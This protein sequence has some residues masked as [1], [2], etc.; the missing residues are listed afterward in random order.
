MASVLL[1]V[2]KT[3]KG[4][5]AVFHFLDNFKPREDVHTIFSNAK[6]W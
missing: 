3:K 2:N 4:K 1:Y 6:I 5:K